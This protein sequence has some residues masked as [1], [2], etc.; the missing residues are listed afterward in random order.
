MLFTKRFWYDALERAIKTFAQSAVLAIGASQL[1]VFAL[2]W[3]NLAGFALGGAI[4]SILTSMAGVGV[5]EKGT[6]SLVKLPPAEPQP[7]AKRA[8]A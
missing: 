4:L 6:A 7:A 1:N 5:G 2:D 8:V 3:K